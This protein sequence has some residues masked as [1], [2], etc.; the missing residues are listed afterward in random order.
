MSS[1]RHQAIIRIN[2]GLLLIGPLGTYLSQIFTKLHQLLIK[3][4]N[5]IMQNVGYFVSASVSWMSCLRCRVSPDNELFI[6]SHF[7]V[8]PR[9]V[10]T[11]SGQ[12]EFVLL[13]MNFL[14]M[15]QI[16]I[17][18]WDIFYYYTIRYHCISNITIHDIQ[19]SIIKDRAWLTVNKLIWYSLHRL[20]F[21]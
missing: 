5:L 4:I 10:L 21:I 17:I 8:V 9:L 1:I 18:F 14:M 2:A 20:R 11:L 13:V 6:R 19:H 3:K 12:G 16:K 15:V 7:R